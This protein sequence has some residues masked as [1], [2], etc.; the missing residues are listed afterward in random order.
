MRFQKQ[1]VYCGCVLFLLNSGVITEYQLHD[2]IYDGMGCET[3][4]DDMDWVGARAL[5]VGGMFGLGYGKK[6]PIGCW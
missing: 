4:Y 3:R 5:I 1:F 6:K 2:G